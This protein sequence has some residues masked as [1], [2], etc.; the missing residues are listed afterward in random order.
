M[1]DRLRL[2][3]S[4]VDELAALYVLDALGTDEAAQVAAHLADHAQRHA[5]FA[6]LAGITPFLAES[7]DPMAP[8]PDL[9]AR[10]MGAVAATPQAVRPAM[11]AVPPAPAAAPV[12]GQA[13]ATAPVP[14]TAY[15][16]AP[17]AAAPPPA[18]APTAG[19]TN[20][21]PAMPD[22]P[23]APVSIDQA[24]EHRRRRSP[25]RA[26][27]A[28]AAVIAIVALGGWNVLL[29][30]QRAEADHRLAL[31]SDA[32]SAAGQ[33]GATVATMTGS[34]IAEGA[35]GFAVFPAAGPGYIVLTGLPPVDSNQAWQAWT[36]AE[37]KPVS[38][39][40]VTVGEDGL[41]VLENVSRIPG[42]SIV[43]LTVE[44]AGGS[45]SPTTQPVVMGQLGSPL[46]RS[47]G[48]LLASAR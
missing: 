10:V 41:A 20:V 32:V 46:A 27:V 48:V 44:P 26:L 12:P 5:S 38:A 4:D 33:P 30:Q 35:G 39:G 29:Q 3:C 8:P 15:A 43:A 36:L 23:A 47:G 22:V 17:L 19:W 2:S 25:I 6:E 37:G 31:L 18:Y 21:P 11:P 42:T 28:L 16:P 13:F 7:I 14:G 34:D 45:D 24:R 40:L 1:T 9:R